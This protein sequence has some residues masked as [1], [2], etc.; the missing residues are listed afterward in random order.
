MKKRVGLLTGLCV[1]GCLMSSPK[2]W[3]ETRTLSLSETVQPGVYQRP[4]EARIWVQLRVSREINEQAG[5]YLAS[6]PRLQAAFSP[7]QLVSLAI[8]LFHTEM[9]QLDE[10]AEIKA[11]LLLDTSL[12]PEDLQAYRQNNLYML[13]SIAHHQARNRQL[14]TDFGQYLSAI[15][16]ASSA[17]QAQYLRQTR[18]QQLMNQYQGNR[19]FVDAAGLIGRARWSDAI[20]KLDQAIS[21]DP[22]YMGSY[23]LKA[24]CHFQLKQ[25]DPALTALN[26]GIEI[27][28]TYEGLY[29]FRG[30]TYLVQGVLL[31]KAMADFNQTLTLNPNNAQAYYLRAITY[32]RQGQCDR[33]RQD[34]TKACSLGYG[35]AC[36]K[37]CSPPTQDEE[38]YY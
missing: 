15:S 18:G 8:A 29:F 26:Q 4:D 24:L 2:A 22:G 12:I 16:Q 14:E 10:G 28:P 33:A 7:E 25:F 23:F 13:E 35:E 11:K 21:L 1:L 27:E 17:E 6:L 20:Q 36:P 37:D 38:K 5:Q 3:A 32:R 34:F 30:L 19:A 31:N 9:F